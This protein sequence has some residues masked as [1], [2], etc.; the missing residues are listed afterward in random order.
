MNKIELNH[1]DYNY[2]S[3][4]ALLLSFRFQISSRDGS[5]KTLIW[6]CNTYTLVCNVPLLDGQE[7]LCFMV[8]ITVLLGAQIIQH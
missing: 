7:T 8:Y 3:K 2:H 6:I 1:N 5:Y 4:A